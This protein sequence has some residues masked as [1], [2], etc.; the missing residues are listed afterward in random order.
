MKAK[1]SHLMNTYYT[2]KKSKL[3]DCNF[4]LKWLKNEGEQNRSS[5]SSS[6]LTF[7]V[8]NSIFA[9]FSKPF[10]ALEVRDCV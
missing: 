9:Q 4:I 3:T 8:K 2:S 1:T 6:F 7:S 10:G 5:T